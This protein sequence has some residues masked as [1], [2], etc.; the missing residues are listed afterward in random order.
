MGHQIHATPLT[1]EARRAYADLATSMAA[2][3]R[4]PDACLQN[5]ALHLTRH[6]RSLSRLAGVSSFDG[7]VDAA[8]VAGLLRRVRD[9]EMRA[10]LKTAAAHGAGL[11]FLA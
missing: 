10:F 8:D 7:Q 5:G 3:G 11:V 1:D 2:D 4:A 9:P 6:V